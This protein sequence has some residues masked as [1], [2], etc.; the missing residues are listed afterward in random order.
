[1]SIKKRSVLVIEDCEFVRE[2]MQYVLEESGMQVV[3]ADDG[4]QG[5]KLAALD[6]PD[7]IVMDWMMPKLTGHEV[8]DRLKKDPRTRDIPVIVVSART[9]EQNM[10]NDIQHFHSFI[11]KDEETL[12]R[13]VDELQQFQAVVA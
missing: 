10:M 8:L 6:V 2:M 13:L 3:T 1:M 5:L 12:F 11:P 4:E 9:L 7:F